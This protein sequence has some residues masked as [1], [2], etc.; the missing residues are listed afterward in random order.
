MGAESFLLYYGLR[1][2]VSEEEIESMETKT[3]P[4][5]VEAVKAGLDSWWGNYATDGGEDYYFFVGKQ[6]GVFGAEYSGFLSVSD[7]GLAQVLQETKEKLKQA[8]FRK[9]ATLLAQWEPDF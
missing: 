8:G 4:F 7:E 3:H 2:A 5:Q 6:L 1:F 9:T